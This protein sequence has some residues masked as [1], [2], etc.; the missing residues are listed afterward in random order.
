MIDITSKK[1]LTTRKEHPC[2]GCTEAI[3][4]G[5]SAAFRIATSTLV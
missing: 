1:V 2:F 4:K 5:A 3:N